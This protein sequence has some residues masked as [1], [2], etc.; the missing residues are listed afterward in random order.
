MKFPFLIGEKIYLR[1]LVESDINEEYLSWINDPEV[2]KYMRWRAFPS[3]FDDLRS[4]V[5]EKKNRENILLAIIDKE[6]DKHIGNIL[7]GHID[8]INRFAD[9]AMVIGNK[10]Y[11]GKGYMSEAFKLITDHAFNILNLHKL[12]A[13]T[14]LKNEASVKFFKK[15]GWVEE[16]ILKDH[17]LYNGKFHDSVLFAIFNK[18]EI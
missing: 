15:I 8:W 10:E 18:N 14:E 1:A 7:L 4:F 16:A 9:L 3:T 17:L 5:N 6:K 2:T 11:W 13:G 12:T